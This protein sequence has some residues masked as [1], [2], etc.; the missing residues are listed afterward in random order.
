MVKFPWI[1]FLGVSCGRRG[2]NCESSMFGGVESLLEV[3][4]SM[5][6]GRCGMVEDSRRSEGSG[7]YGWVSESW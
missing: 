7:I 6:L 1:G 2:R 3:A 5:L 4:M